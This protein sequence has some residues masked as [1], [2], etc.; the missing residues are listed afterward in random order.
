MMVYRPP[1]NFQVNLKIP[2][3]YL[4]TQQIGITPWNF[5]MPG[6]E[7]RMVSFQVPGRLANN[8]KVPDNG[9]LGFLILKK[10]RLRHVLDILKNS[11]N[12]HQHMVKIIG[13]A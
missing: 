7:I 10:I 9:I 6:H 5:R 11:L 2:V 13:D 12:S 3:S 4:V 1:D 8:L